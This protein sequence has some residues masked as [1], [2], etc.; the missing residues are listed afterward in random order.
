[1]E[2]QASEGGKRRRPGRLLRW[3]YRAPVLVYG[4]GLG[5]LIPGRLMLGGIPGHLMLTTVGRRS[6]RLHRVALDM[7]HDPTTDTH[8]VVSGYGEHSD[9]YRNLRANPEVRVQIGWRKFRAR[10]AVLPVEEAEELMLGR[11]R[12]HGRLMRFYG[13]LSL[14][15]VGLKGWSTEEEVRAAV[16]EL[17]VVALHPA[18]DR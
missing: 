16:A 12:Q 14:R 7:W 6:G 17:R 1:M 13:D 8:Y 11:W 10:A 2:Q 4:I 3:F 15:M 18:G 5:G 9:W